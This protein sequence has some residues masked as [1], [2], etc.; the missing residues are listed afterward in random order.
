M[1]PIFSVTVTATQSPC[2]N[3]THPPPITVLPVSSSPLEEAVECCWVGVW[4]PAK[5]NP[6]H[7]P[8]ETLQRSSATKCQE[9]AWFSMRLTVPDYNFHTLTLQFIFS[10]SPPVPQRD[11]AILW[12]LL[13]TPLSLCTIF[14][15]QFSASAPTLKDNS[16]CLASCSAKVYG[17]FC[18]L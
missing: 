13:Q 2:L 11:T 15:C 4:L 3:D 7:A 12:L 17:I 14:C 10:A 9:F 6:S 1:V 8:S 18:L 5:S 16:A